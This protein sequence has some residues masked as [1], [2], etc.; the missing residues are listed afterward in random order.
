MCAAPRTPRR[1]TAPSSPEPARQPAVKGV[2]V[3]LAEHFCPDP[4]TPANATHCERMAH[5]VEASG[6]LGQHRTDHQ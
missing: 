4:L 1:T 6:A 5:R 2:G 3:R